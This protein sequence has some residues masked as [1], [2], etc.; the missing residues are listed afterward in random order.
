MKLKGSL[1]QSGSSIVLNNG[2]TTQATL[3]TSNASAATFTLPAATDTI[4]GRAST[5]TLTNKTLDG[6]SNTFTNLPVG[7]ATGTLSAAHGGTGVANNAA[8]TITIS[9]AFGTTLT[10]TSTTSVTLPTAGTLATLAGAES[11]TNKTFDSTSTLTGA[12]LA[13]FTPDGTHTLTCPTSTD[14]LVARATVDTLSNKTLDNSNIVTLKCTLFGL[15]DPTDTTKQITFSASGNTTAKLLTLASAVTL[16]RTVTFPDATDTLVGRATTDTLTNKT[17]TAPVISTIVNTGTLTLPTSTDTLVGRATTD[18]LTN[19]TLTSPTLTTP[20]LGT[21][22]SGTLTNCTGLPMTTG[23]TGTLGVGNG[24]TGVTTSTGSGAN[25]LGTSPTLATPVLSSYADLTEVAKP[26]NPAASTLRVYAKSDDK[27]YTLNSSGTET[28][29]GAGS[30]GE[31]NAVLNPN[32]AASG[33]TGG[34]SHTVTTDTTHSPLSPVISTSVSIVASATAAESST[35]GGYYTISTF[36]T[37]LE[38][39]KMKVEFWMTSS[40]S[41][42]WAVSVYSGSTRKSLSTDSSGATTLPA[43]YT[44]KFTTTFDADSSTAYT[45]NLTRTAGSGTTTLYVTDVIVGPGIVTQG[46]AVS[47]WTSYTPTGSWSTNTTYTGLFRRVG[48]QMEAQ[49]KVALSGAPTSAT[50]SVN[51]LPT[52]LT[53]NTAAMI[54]TTGNDT[55]GEFGRV[56]VKCAAYSAAAVV[57][58]LVYQTTTAVLPRWLGASGT[59]SKVVGANIDQATPGTFASGDYIEMWFTVPINE[60]AGSGTLNCVQNDTLFAANNGALVGV[61]GTN[62][63]A[64]V[65]GP[66]GTPVLDYSSQLG[67]TQSE[68]YQVNWQTPISAQDKLTLEFSPDRVSWYSAEALGFQ[69]DYV[70]TTNTGAKLVAVDST[71]TNVVFYAYATAWGD[72][73]AWTAYTSWYWRVRKQA[74]GQAVGFGIVQ[75][76]TSAGLVSAS[77]LTGNTTGTAIAAGYVGEFP[78][79]VKETGTGGFTYSTQNTTVPTTS[80]GT[81]VSQTLNK[82]IY[83]VSA[84]ISC[85]GSATTS[86]FAK[87][88][89]GGTLVTQAG[90]GSTITSTT[91]GA[92]AL[93]FPV[94]ITTDATVVAIQGLII[95]GTASNAA[96]E[97]WSVRIA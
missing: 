1:S 13:S 6:A 24:G 14:T 66:A 9:G 28:Q 43:N 89:I 83:L 50:L 97:M 59:G 12:R 26:A 8:S 88:L 92:V 85:Q 62:T 58:N 82:G 2:A 53:L 64:Y 47:D 51:F 31:L 55:G 46:A 37:G 54:H 40:A 70:G 56:E 63:S 15:Q 69:P 49:I 33:W 27:L 41:Q 29:V 5:D 61:N 68:T 25:V 94:Q 93:T 65:Y 73:T 90:P 81:V 42:T 52:G 18:T 57:G 30:T 67:T 75:P 34:T 95:T 77:G 38:N 44:G 39:R 71:H 7:S 4:V 60:W 16:N 79:G 17:L 36:P 22:A 19:K 96:N 91:Q 35:S 32:D 21:P 87:G 84:Y 72:L 3:T 80:W 45:V 48:S 76:G 23:V 74:A 10:V 11:L 20:V 78:A 86:L